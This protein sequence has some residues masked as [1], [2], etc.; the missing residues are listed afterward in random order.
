MK[1]QVSFEFFVALSFLTIIFLASLA[2]YNEEVKNVDLILS[3]MSAQAVASDFSRAINGVYQCGDG[4][5]YR[6]RLREGYSIAVYGRVVEAVGNSQLSQAPLVT[7][8]VEMLS[9]TPGKEVVVANNNGV[10]EL[11]D[12]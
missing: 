9:A 11:H 7:D 2:V 6:L 8:S 3:R 12:A 10:I 1:A 4:C 5:S